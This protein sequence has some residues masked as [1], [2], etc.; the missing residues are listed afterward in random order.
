M[1]NLG[2]R[3]LAAIAQFLWAI[4]NIRIKFKYVLLVFV[5]CISGA[6]AYTYYTMLNNVGGKDDYDEAMRYIQIKDIIDESYIEEVDR[7]ALGDVHV[8]R[9]V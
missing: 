8:C 5:V 1:G 3:M 7:K 2:N 6:V 4:L 9:R